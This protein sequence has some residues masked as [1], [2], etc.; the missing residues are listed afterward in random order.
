MRAARLFL[1]LLI[2]PAGQAAEYLEVKR[3]TGIYAEP[4]KHSTKLMDVLPA[5]AGQPFLLEIAG[6]ERSH[7]YYSIYLPSGRKKGWI[8]KTYV[9]RH[10]GP[11]P[12]YT[13]YLRS[14]YKHWIDADNDCQDSRQEVLIRDSIGRV[15]FETAEN[16]VVKHGQWVDPYTGESFREPRQLDIDHVVPLKNAHESGAWKWP[17]EKRQEF[18]NYLADRRHLLAVKASENRKK[19]AK[20]PDRYMPPASAFHCDYVQEWVRIKRTWGLSLTASEQRA[21]T[22][23]SAG[24]VS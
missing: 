12:R 9:R 21:V 14:L 1:F 23:I 22:A 16:C 2:S 11:E 19:G 5:T 6:K 3:E 20:G 10:P 8:Y 17:A 4:A 7:G 13:V 24:C 15:D 18:A